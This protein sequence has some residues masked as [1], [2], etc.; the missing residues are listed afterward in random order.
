[1]L[2]DAAEDRGP[3]LFAGMGIVRA[4]EARVTGTLKP[5]RQP[6]SQVRD[7]LNNDHEASI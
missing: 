3:V 6:P 5:E 4:L 1:M 2:I 7:E